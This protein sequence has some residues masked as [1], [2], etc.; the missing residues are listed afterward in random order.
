MSTG[1]W[2]AFALGV[3]V[4][5]GIAD[6]RPG[7]QR[8]LVAALLDSTVTGIVVTLGMVPIAGRV[9]ADASGPLWMLVAATGICAATSLTLPTGGS[10]E[11]PSP[12]TRVRDLGVVLPILAGALLLAALHEGP[13]SAAVGLIVPL[14]L[15]GA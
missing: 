5:L 10:L 3:L 14:S 8:L 7:E 2:M 11:P 6:R 4:G 13:A 9:W 15:S 12:A 1:F